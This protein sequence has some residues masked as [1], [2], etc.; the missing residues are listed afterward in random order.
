RRTDRRSQEAPPRPEPVAPSGSRAR[1]TSTPLPARRTVP[2]AGRERRLHAERSGPRKR[3]TLE[4]SR[5]EPQG[6]RTRSLG[7]ERMLHPP[8]AAEDELADAL[9]RQLEL[10]G[11][12]V[13]RSLRPF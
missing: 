13:E 2:V 1:C 5:P 9:A 7:S 6:L 11:D 3:S 4:G 12:P 10:R 8:K